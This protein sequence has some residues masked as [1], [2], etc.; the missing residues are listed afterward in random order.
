VVAKTVDRSMPF[1][2]RVSLTFEQDWGPPVY[3]FGGL[4]IITIKRI[5]QGNSN[6]QWREMILKGENATTG[7]NATFD[8]LEHTT[9]TGTF[10]GTDTWM[11]GSWKTVKWDK[12]DWVLN[13]QSCTRA[14]HAPISPTT[15]TVNKAAAKFYKNLRKQQVQFSAPTFIGELRDTL[16]QIRRPAEALY[17]GSKSFLDAVK[18]LK[19]SNP[20]DWAEKLSGLW[21]EYSFGWLPLISDTEDA[22]K[23][24]RRIGKPR[25]THVTASFVDDFDMTSSLVGD[26]IDGVSQGSGIFLDHRGRLTEKVTA[27]YRGGIAAQAET[28]Q[29]DNWDLFGFNPSEALPTAWEIL[30]WSFLFDYFTNV[31]D[32]LTANATDTSKVTY[33]NLS[34]IQESTYQASTSVNQALTH[35]GIFG[36]GSRWNT[37]GYSSQGFCTTKRR[38]VTRSAGLGLPIVTFQM[39]AD[40]SLGQKFNVLALLGQANALHPQKNYRWRRG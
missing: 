40:L 5:R 38:V 1:P 12:C 6:P 29:W 13:N 30:P 28:P 25:T 17:S 32:M 23:A 4:G 34:V 21:L 7:L 27:R 11:P 26:N 37:V 3:V 8:K 10:T 16:R 15:G 14:P 24:M 2:T 35:D 31:G 33:V 18:R 36:A 39:D 20:L 19:R 22:C 9:M